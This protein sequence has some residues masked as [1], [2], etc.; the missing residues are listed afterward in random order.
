VCR[1]TLLLPDCTVTV[2]SIYL[3]TT[4]F[5]MNVEHILEKQKIQERQEPNIHPPLFLEN[6]IFVRSPRG[7]WTSLRRWRPGARGQDA[8]VR[9]GIFPP[10]CAPKINQSQKYLIKILDHTLLYQKLQ[11]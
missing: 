5:S 1:T 9:E 6:L 4:I 8:I 11:V 10:G 3:S 2:L 7:L